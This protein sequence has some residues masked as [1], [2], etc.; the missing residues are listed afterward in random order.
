M[1]V[2]KVLELSTGHLKPE[3][4]SLLDAPGAGTILGRGPS[5]SS[6]HGWLMWAGKMPYEDEA[7]SDDLGSAIGVARDLGCEYILF[8]R[9]VEA[10]E[11]LAFYPD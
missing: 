8:D 1:P 5:M 2:I 9:D 3:T 6:E 10:R 11:G 7:F 4:R